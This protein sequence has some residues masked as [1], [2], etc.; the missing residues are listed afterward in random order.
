MTKQ[1]PGRV[2]LPC[3]ACREV[4]PV[5][6]TRADMEIDSYRGGLRGSL[7]VEGAHACASVE[8]TP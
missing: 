2:D 7:T 3:P 5:W 4:V 1:R 8:V 6:I